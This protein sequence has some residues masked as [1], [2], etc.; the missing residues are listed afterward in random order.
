MTSYPRRRKSASLPKM[1]CDLGPEYLA[2]LQHR[3]GQQVL[4]HRAR[5]AAQLLLATRSLPAHHPHRHLLVKPTWT[6]S[7]RLPQAEPLS[8]WRSLYRWIADRSQRHRSHIA[9]KNCSR[10]DRRFLKGRQDRWPFE[11]SSIQTAWLVQFRIRQEAARTR[12]LR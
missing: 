1:T 12:L 3:S 4:E 10:C 8:S 2:V 6:R 9:S 7:A 5:P 11:M